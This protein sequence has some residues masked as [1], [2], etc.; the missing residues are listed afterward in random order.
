MKVAV[1]PSELTT[2]RDYA[3]E[4]DAI[5]WSEGWFVGKV[6]EVLGDRLPAICTVEA[7]DLVVVHGESVASIMDLSRYNGVAVICPQCHCP[8]RVLPRTYS[9]AEVEAV[10]RSCTCQ[11]PQAD[12]AITIV[13]TEP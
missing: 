11:G 3:D 13:R 9:L 12:Q 5:G 4:R 7:V 8:L 6:R 10:L 2:I 1:T